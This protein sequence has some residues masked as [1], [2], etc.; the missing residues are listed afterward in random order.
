MSKPI[1]Q[2]GYGETNQQPLDPKADAANQFVVSNKCFLTSFK[3]F[4]LCE[5]RLNQFH[6]AQK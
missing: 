1:S 5:L 4:V 6:Y 2:S 3:T